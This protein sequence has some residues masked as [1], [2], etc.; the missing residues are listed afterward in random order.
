MIILFVGV[1]SHR[2][3]LCHL[4]STLYKEER[5]LGAVL[6]LE[7]YSSAPSGGLL[8]LLGSATGTCTSSGVEEDTSLV[9]LLESACLESDIDPRQVVYVESQHDFFATE[10]CDDGEE[11]GMTPREI[12]LSAIDQVYGFSRSVHGPAL[13]PGTLDR[14]TLVA[15]VT[16]P[17]HP[18]D[19]VTATMRLRQVLCLFF[20]LVLC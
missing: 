10:E 19:D 13:P 12:E 15:C 6:L 7:S 2:Y 9:G 5:P 1:L 4:S 18:G 3:L 16:P 17:S 8:Q 20:L 11:L 14:D